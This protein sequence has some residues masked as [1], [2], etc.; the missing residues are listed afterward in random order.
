MEFFGSILARLLKTNPSLA[1]GLEEAR[2]LALWPQ[3]VGPAIAKRSR[4]VELR[5]KKLVVEVDHP[6][7]KQQLLTN[8]TVVL[9][10]FEEVL[11]SNLI[12]DLILRNP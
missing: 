4:A 8:K 5:G 10:K 6:I 3:V 2:I 9:K 1:Q 11:G 12:S 7:W